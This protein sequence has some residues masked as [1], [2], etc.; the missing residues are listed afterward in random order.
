MK[1][2]YALQLFSALNAIQEF[3]KKHFS[4][5]FYILFYSIF[6]EIF[7]NPYLSLQMK[8]SLVDFLLL[9]NMTQKQNY[10]VSSNVVSNGITYGVFLIINI[11]IYS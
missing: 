3:E 6:L 2:V 11:L 5:N 9:L 4:S 1:D 7:R 10:R 8:T